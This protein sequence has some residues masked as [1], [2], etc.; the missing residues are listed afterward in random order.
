MEVPWTCR[1]AAVLFT[2]DSVNGFLD[3]W[4]ARKDGLVTNFGALM[5]PLME[6][7]VTCLAFV[8]LAVAVVIPAWV[9]CAVWPREFLITGLR[10]LAATHGVALSADRLGK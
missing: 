3:G 2:I 5:E 9:G 1:W 7:V 6:K 4:L 8:I 10:I